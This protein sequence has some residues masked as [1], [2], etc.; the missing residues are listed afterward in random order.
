MEINKKC[1]S[2]NLRR[3]AKATQNGHNKLKNQNFSIL[4]FQFSV[5]GR[6]SKVFKILLR[7]HDKNCRIKILTLK[8]RVP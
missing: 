4:F 8:N 6:I 1:G 7:S 3:H 2:V 5:C